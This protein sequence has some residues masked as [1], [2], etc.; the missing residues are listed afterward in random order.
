MNDETV[1]TLPQST[2]AI[3]D[4]LNGR[5]AIAA[6]RILV[7][8]LVQIGAYDEAID[9]LHRMKEAQKP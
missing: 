4:R 9:C 2:A 3:L 6:R 5:P 8:C 7:S 1:D